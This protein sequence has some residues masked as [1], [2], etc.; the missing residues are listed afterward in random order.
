M[1]SERFVD[2]AGVRMFVREEGGGSPVFLLH[3]F[4]QTGH[5]WRDVTSRLAK[6]YRVVVPDLPGFGLSARPP[7]FSATAVAKILVA[8]AEAVGAPRAA[9][10]GHDWGGSFSLALALEAPESVHKLVVTNAPFRKIDFKR[11]FHFLAFNIP[12]VPELAFAAA[13]D[14]IVPFILR[15]ASARKEV[16]DGDAVRPY[17]EAYASRER[18]GAALAYYRTVTRTLIKRA[19]LR[20]QPPGGKAPRSIAAPTLIVWGDRDPVLPPGLADGIESDIGDARVVHLD[21]IGHFVP[22]EAPERLAAE[23]ESFIG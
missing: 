9:W 17:Q 5:C 20:S 11:G 15:A 2:A 3:G 4:P 19:L 23:I 10:V 16:F 14:R 7:S 8:L 18:V 12:V 1:S 22:E 21:G 13:G 6:R